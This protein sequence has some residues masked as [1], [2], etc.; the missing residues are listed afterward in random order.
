MEQILLAYFKEHETEIV[1]DLKNLVLH[2]ASTADI[3]ELKKTRDALKALIEER[4]GCAVTV[5]PRPNGHD[6]IGF[7]YGK[8]E[9]KVVLIGHYDTVHPVGT[10]PMHQEGNLLYG[11]GVYDMKS[12]L[13]SAVWAV[14]AYQDLGIDP[15]KKLVYLFNGD[16]ETGSQESKELIDETALG[17]KAA[18]ICEPAIRNG[19]LKT[20]RKGTG[21]YIVTLKGKA[22]HAGNAHRD[23][24]NA[25]EEMAHEIIYIQG[26]TDYEKGT[27]LNVG[28][29]DG[30][31]KTNVVPEE[32]SF[33][34]DLRVKVKAERDRITDLIM[35]M[36]ITV[37]GVTRNVEVLPGSPPMM[38]TAENMALFALAQSCGEKLGM[39][40]GHQFVGGGSDGNHVADLGVPTLDS[41][42]TVGDNAHT[43]NEYIV[44][45]Q[46]M[47]RIALL[48]SIIVRI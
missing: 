35:H 29:C 45:D 47:E 13:V 22:A 3:A 16:E 26:L 48:S 10:F 17:A 25:I 5:Y 38:E 14:K 36:P 23:G 11:P 40:F 19:D 32:A 39:H 41:M 8:G 4:T 46:Y 21:G 28:I 1:E 43:T 31:T 9:E 44:L 20:G 24:R 27:T 12:G 34:V 2:E 42:G 7:T 33:Q 15:G 30:G 37:E 18:L 6:P